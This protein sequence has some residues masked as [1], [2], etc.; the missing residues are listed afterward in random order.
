MRNGMTLSSQNASTSF[1]RQHV[2]NSHVHLFL[3]AF[4]EVRKPDCCD[5]GSCN[6]CILGRRF[7]L[8]EM[9]VRIRE[10]KVRARERR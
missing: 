6:L 10:A 8:L 2:R 5:G 3:L 1:Q 4:L 7:R 9:H